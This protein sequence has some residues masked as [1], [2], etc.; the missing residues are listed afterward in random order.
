LFV[1]GEKNET[2]KK[3]SMGN[4]V[5]VVRA[6]GGV[7]GRMRGGGSSGGGANFGTAAADDAIESVISLAFVD[8]EGPKVQALAVKYKYDL[9]GVAVTPA[10]YEVVNFAK[11][12]SD[13]SFDTVVGLTSGTP[14]AVT[15]VY[16]SETGVIDPA[17][18][19]DGSGKY[20]VIELNTAYRTTFSG[21]G[22]QGLGYWRERLIGGVKQVA[23][24][25]GDNGT[26]TPSSVEKKNYEFAYFHNEPND[27]Y[28]GR[29]MVID[30]TLYTLNDLDKYEIYTD[31][32]ALVLRNQ[33]VMA[34]SGSG[35]TFAKAEVTGVT[36]AP[37]TRSALVKGSVFTA[38]CYNETYGCYSEYA[39]DVNSSNADNGYV[40]DVK[41]R[42][43]LFVP[44]DCKPGSSKR[45]ALV[46]HIEDAGVLGPDPMLAQA[47]TSVARNYASD[48]VQNLA[49]AQGLGGLIVVLPQVREAQR[50]VD[51]NLIGGE[52]IPATWQFLDYLVGN[53]ELSPTVI[54]KYNI[55]PNRIYGS[56]QSM[57][58]MQ[59]L[60]MASMRDNYFAG[61]WSIGSQWGSNYNKERHYKSMF[62]EHQ[63]N[64][65]YPYDGKIITNPYWENWAWSV[66]DDNILIAPS[67][68]AKANAYW[69][70]LSDLLLLVN[71]DFSILKDTWPAKTT[72]RAEQN[73]RLKTLTHTYNGNRGMY[74]FVLSDIGHMDWPYTH[75]IDYG[76]DWLLS[77]TRTAETNRFKLYLPTTVWNGTS[78]GSYCYNNQI[79]AGNGPGGTSAQIAGAATSNLPYNSCP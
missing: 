39:S 76:Y 30:D 73:E 31:D 41:I 56:G 72:L 2:G 74:W 25:T 32:N 16:I 47:E 78:S 37:A 43:S 1:K 62:G 20:V 53:S 26:V 5:R 79:P 14:G 58:G 45:C 8:D 77:Q 75:A 12:Q 28:Y 69:Q 6:S 71:P 24:L 48:R 38:N 7:R 67:S 57:G 17:G 22:T 4:A 27:C 10:A 9:K 70:E 65:S 51:D 40:G 68:D 35:P 19:G 64:V 42:Y 55:D 66:S 3:F 13:G 23:A 21:N 18:R 54:G 44:E 11:N 36:I 49:K 52:F 63:N 34:G 15:K 59:V 29:D 61:I 33:T 60:Y 46:I 50:S